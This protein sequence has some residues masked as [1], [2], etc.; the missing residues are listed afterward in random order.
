[1]CFG[2][3]FVAG[4]VFAPEKSGKEVLLVAFW[5]SRALITY[6]ERQKAAWSLLNKNCDFLVE[7]SKF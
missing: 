6:F 1:M 3:H 4:R 7:I 5:N 2:I